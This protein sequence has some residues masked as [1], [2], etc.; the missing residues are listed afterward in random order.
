M[1]YENFAFQSDNA[2]QP[3]ILQT[4]TRLESKWYTVQTTIERTKN[5]DPEIDCLPVGAVPVYA[6]LLLLTP[7]RAH[8]RTIASQNPQATKS[9][10]K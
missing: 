8:G 3:D 9:P 2:V 5:H 4:R 1:R 7:R 10:L 6:A